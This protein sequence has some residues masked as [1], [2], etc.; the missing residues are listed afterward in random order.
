[1]STTESEAFAAW[2]KRAA[3]EMKTSADAAAAKRRAERDARIAKSVA[4]A[5]A[6]QAALPALTPEQHAERERNLEPVG[7]CVGCD[8]IRETNER[9]FPRHTP[10]AR[11]ESGSHP[12]CTC[13]TCW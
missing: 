4:D 6:R 12:H 2:R 13:D 11:C 7:E 5:Y 1:M 8:R 3:A 10:S 9:H